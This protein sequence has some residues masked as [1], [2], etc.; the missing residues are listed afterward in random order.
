MA[1]KITLPDAMGIRPGDVLLS[2]SERIKVLHLAGS[3]NL[4]REIGQPRNLVEVYGHVEGSTS[5]QDARHLTFSP[6]DRVEVL[7]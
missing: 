6:A 1:T 2:G 3:R 5:V 4:S 7:R